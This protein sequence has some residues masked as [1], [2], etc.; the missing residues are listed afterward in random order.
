MNLSSSLQKKSTRSR[1]IFNNKDV[2][3]LATQRA[4]FGTKMV[5]NE[6]CKML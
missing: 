6:T 1:S 4:G 5:N 3:Q 2:D